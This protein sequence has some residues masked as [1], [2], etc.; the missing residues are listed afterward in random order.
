MLLQYIAYTD[1]MF[2][3]LINALKAYRLQSQC[4]HTIQLTVN[5]LTAYIAYKVNAL[6]PRTYRVKVFTA[7]SSLSPLS[8]YVA[9]ILS[10]LVAE[11]VN[12][13]SNYL[14][15]TEFNSFTAYSSQSTCFH[16]LQ[17]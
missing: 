6:P 7:N 17:L 9:I 11:R 12:L 5:D 3:Q 13:S 1:S 8:A 14:Y 16:Y 4:S 10:L 2:S 15:V